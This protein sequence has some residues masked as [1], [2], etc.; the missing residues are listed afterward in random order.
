[1]EM[2]EIKER[3]KKLNNFFIKI[4]LKIRFQLYKTESKFR[5]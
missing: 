2:V 1:M 3:K 4:I 5:I